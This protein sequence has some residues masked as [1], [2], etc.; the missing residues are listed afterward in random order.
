MALAM[1]KRRE[2]PRGVKTRVQTRGTRGVTNLARMVQRP[3]PR[4]LGIR[5][6]T[7]RLHQPRWDYVWSTPRISARAPSLLLAVTGR[8]PSSSMMGIRGCDRL[9]IFGLR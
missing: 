9:K 8:S 6:A 3:N 1:V 4:L 5:V 2:Q 7:Q